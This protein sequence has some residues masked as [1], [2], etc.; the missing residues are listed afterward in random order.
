M[1]R[2]GLVQ[3]SDGGLIDRRV[4]HVLLVGSAGI[5]LVAITLLAL[6]T[7]FPLLASPDGARRAFLQTAFPLVGASLTVFLLTVFG[8]LVQPFALGSGREGSDRRARFHH[9]R[10]GTEG[11]DVAATGPAGAPADD[12]SAQRDR[13]D[14]PR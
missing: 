14:R 11:R 4:S 7:A 8:L 10:T 12:G 3:R 1:A 2:A 13:L 6:P 9:E 5:L